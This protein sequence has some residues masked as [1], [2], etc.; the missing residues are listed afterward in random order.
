MQTVQLLGNWVTKTA[1]LGQA[2]WPRLTTGGSSKELSAVPNETNQESLGGAKR[3]REDRIGPDNLPETLTLEFSPA[4]PGR[5]L[6]HLHHQEGCSVRM[7]SQRQSRNSPHYRKTW[8]CEPRGRAVLLG[9]LNLLLS[10]PAPRYVLSDNSFLPSCNTTTW[11]MSHHPSFLSSLLSFTLF[12][13]CTFENNS[14]YRLSLSS[15]KFICWN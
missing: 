1:H 9:S 6:S 10:T 4:P 15:P 11:I 2:R 14:C 7:I 12:F 8:S 5:M 13:H 3:K